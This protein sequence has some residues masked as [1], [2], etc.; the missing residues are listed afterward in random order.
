[1]RALALLI[2]LFGPGLV[3]P[4]AA[5][6]WTWRAFSSAPD[7]PIYGLAASAAGGL[8]VLGLIRRRG[9]LREVTIVALSCVWAGWLWMGLTDDSYDWTGAPALHA[10]DGLERFAL[11]LIV[12]AYLILYVVAEAARLRRV[13]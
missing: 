5:G 13:T 8:V 6:L 2:L 9:L 7:G 4:A 12:L 3:V 10:P 1:M 11:L